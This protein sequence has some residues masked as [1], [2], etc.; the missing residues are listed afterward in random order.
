MDAKKTTRSAARRDT[1][2]GRFVNVIGARNVPEYPVWAGMRARCLRPTHKLWKH[3]GGRGITVCERWKRSFLAF[4]EDM[5]P[6]PE[7]D[8][9]HGIHIDRID[10]DGPYS[11]EN[12]RW[13]TAKESGRNRGNSL[14]IT[15]DGKEHNLRDFAEAHGVNG[16]YASN[17]IRRG[18]DPIMAATTPAKK[19]KSNH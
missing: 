1:K 18:W 15:F 4:M 6:R 11:P 7:S 17:R 8:L 19:R 10:N 13:A 16:K 12:C 2:T 3:Y 14:R 5:G 9:A